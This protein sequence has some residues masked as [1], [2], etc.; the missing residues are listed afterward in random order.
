MAILYHSFTELSTVNSEITDAMH[1]P[2]EEEVEAKAEVAM[3]S[4]RKA[5]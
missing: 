4:N 3:K 2:T 1:A 5:Q